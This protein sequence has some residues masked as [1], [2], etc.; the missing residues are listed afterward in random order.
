MNL[1]LSYC[2]LIWGGTFETHLNSV[3]IQQKKIIRLIADAPF[4]SHTTPLFSRLKI[5]K[6]TDI[7]KL[8]LG[9]FMYK[10]GNMFTC[11]HN[12]NTRNRNQAVPF[13]HRLTVTQHSV[14]FKGPHFW[15]SLPENLRNADSLPI[16]KR[17]LKAHLLNQYE[18]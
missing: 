3:I 11:N 17:L 14:T 5:L 1:F 7:Y 8:N 12:L 6:F 15:N 16:F 18:D 9:I 10:S 13:R 4:L 2:V